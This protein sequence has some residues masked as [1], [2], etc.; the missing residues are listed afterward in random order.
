MAKFKCPGAASLREARPEEIPCRNCGEAVEIWSD[1]ISA[2]CSKCGRQI[3][4][5]LEISCVEWC[6]KAGE[7]VGDELYEKHM[8]HKDDRKKT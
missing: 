6:A 4:R 3:T 1:E 8:H 5:E 2:K 7:C